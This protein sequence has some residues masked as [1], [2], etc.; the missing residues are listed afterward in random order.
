MELNS[1]RPVEHFSYARMIY[2]YAVPGA[3]DD[4]IPISQSDVRHLKLPEYWWPE[5]AG[6]SS[7]SIFYQIEDIVTDKSQ[8]TLQASPQW[9]A[10]NIAIWQPKNNG[11]SLTLLLPVTTTGKYMLGLTVGK[12]QAS[13]PEIIKI[14][15]DKKTLKFNDQNEN[16]VKTSFQ[17]VARNLM[18]EP[19]ELTEGIHTMTIKQGDSGSG[20]MGLDF[21]WVKML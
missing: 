2:A 18:S 3:Y 7:N 1:H 9:A 5:G 15:L 21:L 8:I 20:K 17:P 4:H 19:V 12:F 13:H 16:D 11:E 10:K 6:A 14:E